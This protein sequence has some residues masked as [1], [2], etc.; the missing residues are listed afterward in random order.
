[1]EWRTMSNIHFHLNANDFIH[2]KD[3]VHAN[4]AIPMGEIVLAEDP[5]VCELVNAKVQCSVCQ[6][7]VINLIS[8]DRKLK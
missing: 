7:N 3:G 1:M 5:Y 4:R 8:Y 2:R 6:D